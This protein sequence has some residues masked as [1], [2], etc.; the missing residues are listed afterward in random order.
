MNNNNSTDIIKY[1]DNE[2][3]FSLRN[4]MNVLFT[5]DTFCLKKKIKLK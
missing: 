5:Y 1:D 2:F 4:Q 3:S